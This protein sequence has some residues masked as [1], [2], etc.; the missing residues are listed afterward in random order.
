MELVFSDPL[1]IKQ[2]LGLVFGEMGSTPEL[3]KLVTLNGALPSMSGNMQMTTVTNAVAIGVLPTMTGRATITVLVDVMINSRLP[4]LTGGVAVKYV[5]GAVRPTVAEPV[6]YWQ[7]TQPAS[8]TVLDSRHGIL[9]THAVQ[10]NDWR[11]ARSATTGILSCKPK[12]VFS[13]PLLCCLAQHDAERLATITHN[14]I[15]QDGLHDRRPSA[16][17]TFQQGSVTASSAK[18]SPW[19]CAL[20]ASRNQIAGRWQSAGTYSLQQSEFARSGWSLPIGVGTKFEAAMRPQAGM[21]LWPVTPVLDPCYV[22]PLGCAVQLLFIDTHGDTQ[23]VFICRQETDPAQTIVVPKL[24]VYVVINSAALIRVDGNID[25]PTLGMT[26]AIDYESW[27][28]S[29]TA[30]LPERTLRDLEPGR[31][32]DPVEVE[33]L[34]NGAPYRFIVE[35]LSRERTFG[36]R[37]VKIAGRGKSAL[38]DTPY[39]PNS[40]FMNPQARTAQQ[41][42]GDVLTV[43]GVPLDWQVDW[44]L[45]D[46][47][48]PAGVWSH[49]GSYISALNRIASAA[50]GYIQPHATE[51]QLRILPIYPKPA[52]EWGGITPDYELP[53][54]VT[55]REAIEWKETPRYNRV[56]VSGISNGV[57]GQVTRQG[58]AGDNIATMVTDS[59]ITHAD[60]ARQRG[61]AILSDTGRRAD[62]TLK[63]PVLRETGII[64]PGKFIDYED[65]STKRRGIVRSTAVD[66]GRPEIWQSIGVETREVS[67]A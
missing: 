22:P 44:Q 58:T 14:V 36:Q 38:L 59:L 10:A 19:Q 37:S 5:S 33:A 67:R 13:T 51:A 63:L 45:T 23:L 21:L 17:T 18:Q 12:T 50:G 8:I 60:A 52:W 27:T 56:F 30:S 32:G 3:P 46:W 48:V 53:A 7:M 9:R 39:A 43:N 25:L 2:P 49:Q 29:F 64:V 35:S 11:Q 20:R 62:I 55:T 15:S 66:V 54:D 26:L 4:T 57:L 65:G 1:A 24:R 47:L 31:D 28:W 61:V 6:N 40:Y 16:L 34:I 42:M 41:L